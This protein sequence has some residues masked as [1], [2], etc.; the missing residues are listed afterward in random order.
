MQLGTNNFLLDKV[1]FRASWATHPDR[2]AE[3][4][5]IQHQSMSDTDMTSM[6]LGFSVQ[7]IRIIAVSVKSPGKD[8]ILLKIRLAALYIQSEPA[9]QFPY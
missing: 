1:A 5:K 9:S 4:V 3:N 6:I 7:T 8:S 2:A